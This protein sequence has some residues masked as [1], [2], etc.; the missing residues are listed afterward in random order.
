[1]MKTQD[2][3]PF[4]ELHGGVTAKAL[5]DPNPTYKKKKDPNPFYKNKNIMTNNDE[6]LID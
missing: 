1:M 2:L 6:N 4:Q 5:K 3:N